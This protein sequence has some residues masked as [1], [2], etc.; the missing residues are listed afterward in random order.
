MSL[1]LFLYPVLHFFCL[2]VF[3]RGQSFWSWLKPWVE[4][5]TYN[6]LHLQFWFRLTLCSSCLKTQTQKKWH[7]RRKSEQEE[8]VALVAK[9][10]LYRNPVSW[11]VS[12]SQPHRS[13]L[14]LWRIQTFL[15]LDV[16]LVFV[17]YLDTLRFPGL[18]GRSSPKCHQT[19]ST[20]P[21]SIWKTCLQSS[22][23]LP[24]H[25]SIGFLDQV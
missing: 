1:V 7:S 22:E 23:V 13:L 3:H 5:R 8:M 18:P 6:P 2:F 9:L 14:E 19:P 25:P 20:D 15:S 10:R 11:L 16:T 12:T 4:V 17:H 21:E 24:H